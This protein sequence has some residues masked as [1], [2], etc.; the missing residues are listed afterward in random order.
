MKFKETTVNKNYLYKGR[1]INLRND[2]VILPN[3]K[4]AKREIIEH[5][6]GSTILCVQDGKVLMV[7]QFRYAYGEEI[8]EL[9]AG[10]LNK[11]E[12]PKETARREL[13]EECGVLAKDLTLL[14]IVYPTPGYTEEIIRI[15]SA[16]NL[17]NT[18]QN[19]DED[20]FLSVKWIEISTL[21]QMVESGE[22]KDAKTL[23]ALLWLFSQKA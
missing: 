16:E 15:Y 14:F 18:Q 19:L 2:D 23:I 3:G 11:G 5:S 17:K 8:W 21:K 12:D 7:K 22:I 6:G 4:P 13:E 9:P 1:I 10:K 20:E